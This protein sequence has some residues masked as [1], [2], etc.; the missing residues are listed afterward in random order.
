MTV[1]FLK[2][3][4]GSLGKSRGDLKPKEKL[5]LTNTMKKAHHVFRE[6]DSS[7]W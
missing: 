4:R 5:M 3:T 1:L 6:Q 2:M 7:V